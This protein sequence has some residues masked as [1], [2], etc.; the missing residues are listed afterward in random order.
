MVF[1][2]TR[3]LR[4]VA[5]CCFECFDCCLKCIGSEVISPLCRCCG[6]WVII[7][8]ERQGLTWNKCSLMR[9]RFVWPVEN[10]D[11]VRTAAT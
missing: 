10:G 5:T 4:V 2:V 6:D 8:V 3:C 9:D 7:V 11:E 1:A